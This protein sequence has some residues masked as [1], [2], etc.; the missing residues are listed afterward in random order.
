MAL[1]FKRHGVGV[2]RVFNP[3]GSAWRIHAGRLTYTLGKNPFRTPWNFGRNIDFS[4]P[5]VWNGFLPGVI[6]SLLHRHPIFS[7]ND[8]SYYDRPKADLVDSLCF[9]SDAFNRRVLSGYL[10]L[11]TNCEICSLCRHFAS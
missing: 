2:L 6:V 10:Y 11:V 8:E 9:H 7:Q 4:G 5:G 1:I 3:E